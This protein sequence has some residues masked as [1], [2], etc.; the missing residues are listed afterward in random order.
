MIMALTSGVNPGLTKH[1]FGAK[2]ATVDDVGEGPGLAVANAAKARLTADR[3]A[4]ALRVE[5]WVCLAPD[6][7]LYTWVREFLRVRGKDQGGR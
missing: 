6:H 5:G 4:D 2:G 7:S 3:K 1:G